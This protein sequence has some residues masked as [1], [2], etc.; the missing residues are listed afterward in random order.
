MREDEDEAD[1]DE[2]VGRL[3]EDEGSADFEG[4]STKSSVSSS[5][6]TFGGAGAEASSASSTS[7]PE[8]AILLMPFLTSR[9]VIFF[10]EPS[11]ASVASPE[12]VLGF[13][14]KTNAP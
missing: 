11:A 3:V 6:V 4:C 12:T 8:L 1:K 7:M 2:K 9:A 5:T 10:L 14:V 13:S